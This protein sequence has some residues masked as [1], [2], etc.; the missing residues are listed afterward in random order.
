MSEKGQK[1]CELALPGK[2]DVVANW[3]VSN[4]NQ[5]IGH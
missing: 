4:L 5:I 2:S 1:F 3:I